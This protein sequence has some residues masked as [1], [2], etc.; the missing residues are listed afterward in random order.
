MKFED[1][2]NRLVSVLTQAQIKVGTKQSRLV[3]AVYVQAL[4]DSGVQIPAAV[5][6][7]L[8]CGRSVAG[9][10]DIGKRVQLP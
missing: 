7:M 10:K 6:M 8:M 1:I 3:E 4:R 5:D 2:Q 9:Y